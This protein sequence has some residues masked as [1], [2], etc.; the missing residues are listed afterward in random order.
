MLSGSDEIF[1]AK[2]IAP[3]RL[4]SLPL[5]FGG[6]FGA[7]VL[8]MLSQ[9]LLARSLSLVDFGIFS[10]IA[11]AVNLASPV[12]GF[13]LNWFWVQ[14]FGREGYAAFRWMRG[15]LRLLAIANVLSAGALITYLAITL[16]TPLQSRFCIGTVACLMLFGQC[17]VE[18]L[19]ARFQL[20]DKLVPL[21]VWQA[22]TQLGRFFVVATLLLI[23]V[24]SLDTV[25]F[26]YGALGIG[27]TI[28]AL[29]RLRDFFSLEIRLAGHV[30]PKDLIKA[31]EGPDILAT[32]KQCFPF[33]FIT[34]FYL[35]YFQSSILLLSVFLGTGTTAVF[36][37][38]LLCLSAI[39]LIPN[40]IFTKFL[41][42]P[43]CRW[44]EH[45]ARSF[46]SIL[47]VGVATMLAGGIVTML[48]VDGAA[49]FVIPL[50]FGLKYR[51]SIQILVWLSPTIP[52]RFLQSAY[53]AMLVS[54]QNV[55]RRVK[56]AGISAGLSLAINLLL[57]PTLGILGAVIASIASE[58]I[59]LVLSARGATRYAA[60]VS[61]ISSFNLKRIRMAAAQ[62]LE[63]QIT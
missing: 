5:L 46:E 17:A 44:A 12:A 29:G 34:V 41:V 55:K 13:G 15:S 32:A 3:M 33:A 47:H 24:R 4:H 61:L 18:L 31:K 16:R 21:A 6:T 40:V 14:V 51:A 2:G 1:C 49:S 50:L 62:L 8:A 48:V 39:F 52:I 54:E 59:L 57:L 38:S 9:L 30:R 28:I 60:C 53:S 23:G 26:G 19:S 43:I 25:L 45:D 63:A 36:S 7:A 27:I 11:A 58:T 42:A 22:V 20:E 56:Y 37:A 10:T 35:V